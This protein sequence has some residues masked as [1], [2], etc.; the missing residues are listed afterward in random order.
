MD[1]EEWADDQIESGV[2]L[3]ENAIREIGFPEEEW[4]RVRLESRL[5]ILE[6]AVRRLAR[7][8][9][10]LKERDAAG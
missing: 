1:L 3:T 2:R 9:D 4:T 6:K 7:E 8:I 10:S 5:T